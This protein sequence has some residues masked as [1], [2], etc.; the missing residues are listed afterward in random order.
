MIVGGWQ[1]VV[2]ASKKKLTMAPRLRLGVGA[3]GTVKLPF[4]HPK[5]KVNE[6]VPNQSDSNTTTK[7]HNET[8][9]TTKQ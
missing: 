6:K 7:Q 8:T 2:R 1:R 4:L 3:S 9:T 5:D